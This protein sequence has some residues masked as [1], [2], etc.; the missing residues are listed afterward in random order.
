MITAEEANKVANSN[1]ESLHSNVISLISPLDNNIPLH[2]DH[3]LNM[4]HELMGKCTTF[5]YS[6]RLEK[7]HDAYTEIKQLRQQNQA[8]LDQK[9]SLTKLFDS[10]E[11]LW[12][13][14]EREFAYMKLVTAELAMEEGWNTERADETVTVKYKFIPK[15]ELVSL[16]L[17]GEVDCP[18]I[19]LLTLIYENEL[20]TQWVPFMS[21]SDP[22]KVI[23]RGSKVAYMKLGLPFPLSDR[24][25]CLA[26][27]G[28]DR[29]EENGTILVLAGSVDEN[30]EFMDKHK[31]IK[32][33]FD[34]PKSVKT[35]VKF[36]G[37]EIK[38][39]SATKCF[40]RGVTNVNPKI[41]FLPNSVINW[42][43]RKSGALLFGRL[44]SKAKNIEGT[45]W[46]EKMK[47][48]TEFYGWLTNRL[49][50]VSKLPK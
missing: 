9:T 13:D 6:H 30:E 19:N 32:K 17:E 12:F 20:Y 40:M 16:K 7:S 36:G 2:Q 37:F 23:H 26:G 34:D 29:L 38:P 18:L 10:K 35:D 14:L 47:T 31:L 15:T 8:D 25:I 49:D 46:E 39:I 48:N 11:L 42:F 24:D 43:L 4:L 5:Y 33:S 50:E 27:L 44:A 41:G 22:I 3:Q 21:K 1:N 45:L 28:V